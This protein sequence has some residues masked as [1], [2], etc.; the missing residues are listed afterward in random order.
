MSMAITATLLTACL[1]VPVTKRRQY[2]FVPDNTMDALSQR[3]TPAV[4]SGFTILKTGE[5]AETLRRVGESVAKSTHESWV[6]HLVDSEQAD[7]WVLSSGHMVIHKGMLPIVRNEAG[8]AFLLA[9]LM[10]HDTARHGGERLR[11]QL[12][13]FGGIKGIK[14]IIDT[15]SAM[16]PEQDP[17]VM[18]A[19]GLGTRFGVDFAFSRSHELEADAIAL[20]MV[21]KAGYPPMEGMAMWERLDEA[22]EASFLS[23][24]P[25]LDTRG[26]QALDWLEVAEKP[27]QRNKLQRDTVLDLWDRPDD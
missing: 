5:A 26:K 3:A 27:Y 4:L 13:L 2:H 7:A 14:A 15:E 25:S 6:F 11:Q 16:S 19:M 17:V 10:A 23:T 22:P 1:K 24:H 20:T 18:G 21:A 8:L 9:H 12:D